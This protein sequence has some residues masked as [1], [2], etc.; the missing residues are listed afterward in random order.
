M[1]DI[2]V[3]QHLLQAARISVAHAVAS[4]DDLKLHKCV[5]IDWSD[6]DVNVALCGELLGVGNK[7]YE[8]LLYAAAI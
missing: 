6:D 1:V 4:I 5:V 8:D 2:V 7:V 3:A